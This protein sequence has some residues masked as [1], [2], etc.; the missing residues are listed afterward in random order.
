MAESKTPSN[1]LGSDSIAKLLDV[2]DLTYLADS[3]ANVISERSQKKMYA[4]KQ[5]Y[6]QR[7]TIVISLNTGND[8]VSMRDSSIRF[9]LGLLDTNSVAST[10]TTFGGGSC[11]N[12]FENIRIIAR[13]GEVLSEISK[14]NLY[15]YFVLK[16]THQYEWRAEQQGKQLLGFG[17]TLVSGQEFVVPLR[18][19]CEFFRDDVLL[20]ANVA[21]GLRIE[22]TLASAQSAFQDE[23]ATPANRVASYNVVGAELL[24]DSYR[25]SGSAQNTLNKMASTSGL[26]LTYCDVNNSRTSKDSGQSTISTEVR[27]SV[28]MANSVFACIRP[29]ADTEDVTDDSFATRAVGATDSYQYRIGSV[30]LPQERISGPVQWYSQMSY[31]WGKT[32]HGTQL[33]IRASEFGTN[34]LAVGDI[35]RYWTSGSG[36][37]INNSTT[38]NLNA[39]VDGATQ[40]DIDIFLKHTR[41]ATAFLENV[42]VRD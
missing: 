1:S 13:S 17:T 7:E 9:K 34:A 10:Q 23:N 40:C 3:D 12:L 16:L 24:L 11:L 22:L 32:R 6:S 31:A 18:D 2:S 33:G 35:D 28:S 27:Q 42:I 39:T 41:S 20:P 30:Y 21:R 37:A 8:Y 38:L 36:M 29:S 25:L 26:V 14:L 15:N 19:L 5:A 4:Q